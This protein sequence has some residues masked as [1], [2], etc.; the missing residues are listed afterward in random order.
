MDGARPEGAHEPAVARVVRLGGDDRSSQRVRI[1]DAA[2]RCIGAQGLQKTTA[3]D[4]AREAGISRA[5]LYRTFPG[6]KDVLVAGMVEAAARLRSHE[7]LARLLADE[8]G[9]V[10]ARLSFAKL[11]GLLRVAS[12]FAAPF[13]ARWL[14]PDEASRA[15]EWAVRI[16][17]SYLLSPSQGFDLA[18]AG[19][20][21]R[22]VAT[23]VLPG[24]VALGALG[25]P[26]P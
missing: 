10:L 20:T 13:F 12:D 11:D 18:D 17:I 8:P 15:A 24:V 19:Q 14:G 3:D 23:F 6:G 9:V 26:A 4:I 7:P 5:T 16:V 2:L 21:R 22:L 25:D 1:V